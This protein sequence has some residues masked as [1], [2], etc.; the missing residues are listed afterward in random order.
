MTSI[1]NLSYR[2][3][4]IFHVRDG[5][6]EEYPDYYAIRTPSNPSFWFGN[7][8]LFK[9]A[10]RAG[11]LDRWLKIHETV[12]GKTLTHITLGWDEDAPGDNGQFIAAG[13]KT[14]DG[15]GLSM[16]SYTGGTTINSSLV[17][18]SLQSDADWQQIIDLQVEIDRDDFHYTEDNGA[19]RTIQ[20]KGLR[21]MAD[22]GQGDWW[23]AYD[24]GELV[25]GMGLY[26]DV[27]RTI[28]RFQYVTTRA[29]HRRQRVCTTLLDH[30]VQ[31]AF[32]TVRPEQLV[33]STGA[34]ANNPAIKVY[35]NFGFT[36]A[37]RSYAL[38]KHL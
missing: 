33:I 4:A 36:R 10:P 19:F 7:I 32:T 18:R 13:F 20:M 2:T 21:T 25:G 24:Q 6:V 1:K 3:D 27:E 9:H 16:S 17:V 15:I 28:G 22:E 8:I 12:F 14:E 31:H 30:V 29:S 34:D 35:E 11:D 5:F 37:I 26:F 38:I 23:G